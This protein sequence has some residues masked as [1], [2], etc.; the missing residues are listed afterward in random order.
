MVRKQKCYN[1]DLISLLLRQRWS[2]LTCTRCLSIVPSIMIDVRS[3]DIKPP[4]SLGISDQL[5]AP[6]R[7]H[8]PRRPGLNP[9]GEEGLE[10]DPSLH[11]PDD[12]F[13]FVHHTRQ[14]PKIVPV[15]H[16]AILV[17]AIDVGGEIRNSFGVIIGVMDEGRDQY[18]HFDSEIALG[19][20][21]RVVDWTTA[22][23]ADWG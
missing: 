1:D 13:E 6:N 17:A 18:A 15:H 4:L 7:L 19:E 10:S 14:A 2:L 5:R 8:Q 23:R 16:L 9:P 3:D 22:E 12:I 20:E 11:P 21:A